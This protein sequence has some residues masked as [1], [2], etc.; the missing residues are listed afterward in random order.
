MKKNIIAVLAMLVAVDHAFSQDGF[1]AQFRKSDAN[2]DGNL[3]IAEAPERERLIRAADADESGD[4]T[5]REVG[6]YFKKLKADSEPNENVAPTTNVAEDF[7]KDAPITVTSCKAAAAYSDSGNGHAVVV[8]Y[9]GQIV[10]EHYSNGWTAEKAHRLA[11]G[12]KSFSAGMLAAA[13]KDGLITGVDEPVSKTI[14][15]WKS[16]EALAEIT[17][18]HLLSLTSGIDPGSVGKVP[19]Y[20]EAISLSGVESKPGE[21][22]AYGP[23]SFQ[24]FGEVMRRKLKERDGASS[25]PLAFLEAKI[26][27][28]IGMETKL[29]I[30]GADGNPKL[31]SGVLLLATEW[32]KYGEFLR[33]DGGAVLDANVMERAVKGSTANPKYGLTF[34]LSDRGY[35]A[36]GAGKQ[37]LYVFPKEETVVVRFGESSGKKKFDDDV[38]MQHLFSNIEE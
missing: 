27:E 5:L 16:N 26:F 33:T 21:K 7:P 28:P 11:S 9:R 12:T 13:V 36:S 25:D 24:I 1:I 18:E 37:R 29:W 35:Q 3:S 2:G 4:V 30:R 15:E 31:P 23:V 19:T 20:A 8:M 6:A 10:F 38:F 14:T 34:W 32:I 22:F 17:F